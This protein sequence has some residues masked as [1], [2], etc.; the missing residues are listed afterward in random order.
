MVM[1]KNVQGDSTHYGPNY[2]QEY[3]WVDGVF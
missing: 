2:L 1:S 3:F